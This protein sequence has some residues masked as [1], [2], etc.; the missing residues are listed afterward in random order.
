VTGDDASQ[1]APDSDVILEIHREE[2]RLRTAGR[3]ALGV[4]GVETR[5]PM[6]E[7]LRASGAH[8][9]P[10]GALSAMAIVQSFGPLA[11]ALQSPDIAQALGMSVSVIATINLIS[12]LAITLA[13]LPT[14]ALVQN[15]PRRALLCL[16]TGLA[17]SIFI[18]ATAFVVN[19]WGLVFVLIASG[20][21]TGSVS[22]LH[23]PL[24]MDSYPPGVR[25]RVFSFY[26]VAGRLSGVLGPLMVALCTG[27]L[28]L[29]WRGVFA[30]SGALCFIGMLFCL[31]LRDPGF[32]RYDVG[33]IRE[34]VT[35][36]NVSTAEA[37]KDPVLP[38]NDDQSADV[39]VPSMAG[40]PTT[41]KPDDALK[42]NLRFFEIYRRLMLIPTIRRVL[43]MGAMFGAFI[44]PFQIYI[45]FFFEERW[46]MDTSQ[47]A[48]L[49]AVLPLF[50]I[51]ALIW[52]GRRGEEIFRA[53][54]ARLIR[55]M[56]LLVVGTAS[57]VIVAVITP[58]FGLMV[59]FFGLSYMGF[60][61]FGPAVAIVMFSVAHPNTRPHLS[62]LN[63]IYSALIG[64]AGGIL[65]L[66][67]IDSRF[68]ITAALIAMCVP[69]YL[70]AI[71]VRGAAKTV[72]ADLDRLVDEVVEAEELS[73]MRRSG[74]HLPLLACRHVS[75]SYGPL[76]VLF[77]VNFTVDSGEAVALLG[78]N[79][80]GKSTLLRVISGLE[81]PFAG[82][83][84]FGGAEITY[85]DAERRTPL[86]ITTVLGG[87]AIFSSMS[88]V[89]NLRV[90]G[91][92]HGRD[93]K[94]IDAGIE[95][96]LSTFPGLEARRNLQAGLL[97]GGEQQMLSLGQAYMVRPKLLLID[98]LSLGLAPV[99]VANLL[100][101]VQQIN[102]EG[103]AIV[104]VE[105]S[106]NIALSVVEHAYF[107]EK[108]EIRFDGSS[109]DL[110]GRADLL[111]SVF[112][113]GTSKA[114]R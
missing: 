23:S 110:V 69:G 90:Y 36:D 112:L 111:R 6:R 114:L 3:E 44:L 43:I 92:I 2:S 30:V 18:V 14:A 9:Y 105:Q 4:T 38:S 67:G 78:T 82:S 58:V 73:T 62:A 70:V 41:G 76:Q 24:L 107:M 48:L 1:T 16:V 68:G 40:V 8:W 104:L 102:A 72:N 101:M 20:I 83:V 99:V 75:F 71:L 94:R 46:G 35:R 85:L 29:T 55:L 39:E 27:L 54:P 113:E 25:V 45:Q 57:C 100:Q 108:G 19:E 84:H 52:F 42:V 32:G 31:R 17:G 88:V 56:S 28:D 12:V 97:S 7:A 66:Q 79:G 26:N 80:A 21:L 13:T 15:R 81:I 64:G 93:R 109:Q 60:T 91:H 98:E 106:V 53:D 51:P 87:R 34:L 5:T 33:K 59:V 22:V 63:G 47:R 49:F 50:T 74:K 89:D 10:L 11:F 77:D 95:T 65:L 103:C 37:A 96:V 61:A 86:G